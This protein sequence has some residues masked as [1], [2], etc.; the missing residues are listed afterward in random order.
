MILYKRR[1]LSQKLIIRIKSITDSMCYNC[2]YDSLEQKT[3]KNWKKFLNN[4]FKI[5]SHWAGYP[6]GNN[7]NST[8]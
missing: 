2:L 4:R 8:R 6:I 1:I 5:V 3:S 7:I